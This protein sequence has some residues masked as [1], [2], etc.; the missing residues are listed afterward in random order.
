MLHSSVSVIDDLNVDLVRSDTARKDNEKNTF[1]SVGEVRNLL[2]V[3]EDGVGCL[4]D[5]V[6]D[7]LVNGLSLGEGV[8]GRVRAAR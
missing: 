4:S 3:L 5:T 6:H 8:L 2:A 1:S 7:D